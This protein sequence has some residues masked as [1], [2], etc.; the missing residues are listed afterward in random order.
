MYGSRVF[1]SPIHVKKISIESP[2]SILKLLRT[3]KLYYAL[4]NDFQTMRVQ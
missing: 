3:S 4:P 1:P 2:S